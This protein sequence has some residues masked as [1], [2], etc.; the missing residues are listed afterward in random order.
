MDDSLSQL[1]RS[2]AEGLDRWHG[3]CDVCLHGQ[4]PA[5]VVKG[6]VSQAEA[7]RRSQA[8]KWRAIWDSNPLDSTRFVGLSRL[9]VATSHVQGLSLLLRGGCLGSPVAAVLRACAET[10]ARAL[11]VLDRDAPPDEAI[12]RALTE[13]L[14]DLASMNAASIPREWAVSKIIAFAEAHDWRVCKSSK[15]RVLGIGE[16][17]PNTRVLL[18]RLSLSGASGFQP[19]IGT[20]QQ[21]GNA[22]VHGNFLAWTELVLTTGGPSFKGVALRSTVA[23]LVFALDLHRRAMDAWNSTIE[24]SPV[25][26]MRESTKAA[27]AGVLN[28]YLDLVI[29]QERANA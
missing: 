10:S 14:H 6:G 18:E 27:F 19:L 7:E 17:R 1:L 26:L 8:D 12:E 16:A 25:D 24:W 2:F 22:A 23:H 15:G 29:A 21:R 13:Q 3:F 11:W 9:E 4:G 28:P 20:F 5:G